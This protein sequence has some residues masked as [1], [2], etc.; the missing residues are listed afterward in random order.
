MSLSQHITIKQVAERAGVSIQTVSRVLNKRPDVSPETR[1]RI[2]QIIEK[3]GY[4]PYASARSLASNHTR[5]LGLISPDFSDYWFAQV[6]TGAEA[7]AHEHGY[8]F[9]LGTTGTNPQDEPKFLR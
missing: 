3:L 6:A 4:K 5:T 7:E 2:Q 9:M 1:E 8:F